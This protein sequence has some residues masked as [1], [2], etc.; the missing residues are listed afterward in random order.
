MGFRGAMLGF[1]RLG[2][3]VVTA[4]FRPDLTSMRE[5]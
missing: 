5:A 4:L 1:F 3:D 2:F